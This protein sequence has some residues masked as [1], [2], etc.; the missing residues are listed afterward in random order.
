MEDITQRIKEFIECEARLC[1]MDPGC[2]TR[3]Y[4]Y[5]MFGARVSLE[6]IKEAMEDVRW[7]R[8]DGRC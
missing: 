3:E 1:S 6:E 5:R 8:D 7:K 2:I 4:V